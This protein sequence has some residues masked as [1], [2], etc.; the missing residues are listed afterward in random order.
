MTLELLASTIG[1]NHI[2]ADPENKFFSEAGKRR[3][4]AMLAAPLYVGSVLANLYFFV[5]ADVGNYLASKIF[6]SWPIQTPLIMIFAYMGNQVSI[7]VKNWELRKEIRY[8]TKTISRF[9][10]HIIFI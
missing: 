10:V 6:N 8:Q 4:H 5:G 7:E 2:Y 3:L 9:V 1:E